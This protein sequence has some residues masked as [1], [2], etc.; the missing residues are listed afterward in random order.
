MG[1]LATVVRELVPGAR[2]EFPSPA[3][4]PTY[5]G[6]FDNSRAVRDFGW[7]VR[8]LE[9]SVRLHIDGVRAEAGLLPIGA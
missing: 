2:I 6:T 9:E 3:R 8:S 4:R 5:P 1:Q 7:Q